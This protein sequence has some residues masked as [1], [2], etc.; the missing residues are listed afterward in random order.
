VTFEGQRFHLWQET[1]MK[2][3]LILSVVFHFTF[4]VVLFSVSVSW[5]RVFDLQSVYQVNLVTLPSP[6]KQEVKPPDPPS[7]APPPSPKPAV[8]KAPKQ[9]KPKVITKTRP[10]K[11]EVAQPKTDKDSKSEQATASI[12][13]IPSVQLDV[14]VPDFQFPFYLKLIQGKIGSL[15]SPP[16]FNMGDELREVVV[17]FTLIATGK[18]KSIQIEKSSGNSFFDQ[19]ALRAVYMADPLPPLPRD[20]RDP[21]LKIHFRFSL[22]R[23]G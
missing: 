5:R 22:D 18:I 9:D 21:N 13:S 20:F 1:S 7:K 4:V 6:P 14:D 2:K 3:M 8:K 23:H 15:W 10:K 19:A 16:D 11:T 17:S 12:P